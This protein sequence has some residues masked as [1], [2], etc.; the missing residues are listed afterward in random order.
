MD[1]DRQKRV[2]LR[3]SSYFVKE[4]AGNLNEKVH[5]KVQ[6]KPKKVKQSRDFLYKHRPKQENPGP[7]AYNQQILR[8][9]RGTAGIAFPLEKVRLW[10]YFR[11]DGGPGPSDYQAIGEFFQG[12][13][14]RFSSVARDFQQKQGKFATPGPADY[15]CKGEIANN[16]HFS[17]SPAFSFTKARKTGKNREK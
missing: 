6:Q 17:R 13:G 1:E 7:G 2:V 3:V 10:S 15:C 4:N 11:S 16:R 5:E 12:K 9:P 14:V 8:K